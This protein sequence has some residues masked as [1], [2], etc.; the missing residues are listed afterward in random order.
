MSLE[1][2]ISLLSGTGFATQPNARL[3]IPALEM[4]DGPVG[5]RFVQ[6][7]T[8]WPASIAIAATFDPVLIGTMAREIGEEA[9]S[10]QKRLLL[11]PTV[12]IARTPWGGRVFES[13]GEDPY[14]SGELARV[15]V[16]GVQSAGVGTSIKHFAVNNQEWGRMHIDVQ[17]S[18]RALREIYLPAFAAGVNAGTVS[19]MAAYNRLNGEYCSENSH[20][21]LD[22][23]KREWG[24]DGFVVSDWGGTHST[25]KAALNG[26][27]LEMPR[28][29][30]FDSKLLS[31]VQAHE[32]EI[33]VIDD[34]LRRILTAIE[35][36]GLFEDANPGGKSFQS[37]HPETALKVAQD[38]IVLL[39]NDKSLLPLPAG[40]KISVLALG[41]SAIHAR[42]GAGGS[43]F[44]YSPVAVSAAEG[45]RR[46]IFEI[47]APVDL[48]VDGGMSLPGDAFAESAIVTGPF[49]GEFFDNRRLEGQ[50]V[51]QRDFPKIDF[52]W[53]W[54][55]PGKGIKSDSEFSARWTASIAPRETGEHV[56]RIAFTQ[57][58]RVYL[59]GALIYDHWT[60]DE[61]QAPLIYDTVKASLA[62]GRTYQLSVEYFKIDGLASLALDI[63]EPAQLAKPESRFKDADYVLLFVGES[64]KTESETFDRTRL[65]LPAEQEELILQAAKAN[66]NTIVV[67]QA[68]GPVDMTAWESKVRSIV[69][70]WYPGEQGGLAIADVLLGLVNPSGRLP[71]S[72]PRT[73]ADSPV[74]ITYPGFNGITAYTDDIF[75]G[76]RYFDLAPG[77]AAFRFGHGLSYTTFASEIVKV[78]ARD[79]RASSPVIEV[80]AR[81]K[82]TGRRAGAYVVQLYVGERA[83]AVVRPLRELKG[84]K[85]VFLRPGQSADVPFTLK[86]EAFRH[87]DD[88][89]RAWTVS[90]GRYQ[91]SLLSEKAQPADSADITLLAK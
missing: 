19:V 14:L 91:L 72:F 81:V 6:D 48:R 54:G 45:L 86:A 25:L 4:T 7:S 12:N 17:V 27:D 1:E 59:D 18:E 40:R 24:F 80:Q 47:D 60:I 65:K 83:P 77:Q 84:F 64:E 13:Y 44:V 71:V 9:R 87:F 52:D 2:K 50:P 57:A 3:G 11:G 88:V 56:F 90:P 35:R 30:Y 8:A 70:A 76:Y 37:H 34:K 41:P 74:A 31:A 15:F 68:G 61:N 42:T 67:V 36:L 21:L 32:I 38:S 85:K 53:G 22:I 5:I 79:A 20:L 75:V 43:S 73:W 51:N 62:A 28:P 49:R 16:T 23:L 69:Y 55:S 39:K 82:N 89:G 29:L 10:Q 63:A 26:L 58:A 66:P 46:R 33:S 78:V